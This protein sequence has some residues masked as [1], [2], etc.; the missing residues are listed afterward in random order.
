MESFLWLKFCS[1]S[2][3]GRSFSNSSQRSFF[4]ASTNKPA[5]LPKIQEF[6]IR[7]YQ[8]LSENNG[9]ICPLRP[10]RSG[11]CSRKYVKRLQ[12]LMQRLIKIFVPLIQLFIRQRKPAIKNNI[13]A[14]A[15]TLVEVEELAIN[16]LSLVHRPP[17]H[18][19]LVL[20]VVE[21]RSRVPLTAL[22]PPQITRS[23]RTWRHKSQQSEGIS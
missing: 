12:P 5:L 3:C 14:I 8:R 21:S 20:S 19:N 23:H 10:K 11:I 7:R 6:L 16:P 15:I 22:S 4:S 18:R 1:V 17:N 13:P 9:A 2:A